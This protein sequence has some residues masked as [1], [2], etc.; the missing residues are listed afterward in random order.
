MNEYLRRIDERNYLT[1]REHRK[2]LDR[3]NNDLNQIELLK[4]ELGLE[5]L[6][7]K[8]VMKQLKKQD[9]IL[10]ILKDKTPF[11]SLIKTTQSQC[12]YESKISGFK[13]LTFHEYDL[14]KEWLEND[15]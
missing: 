15:K 13:P 9:K 4:L 10:E 2:L 14:I 11:L 6:K 5:K 1:E 12:E 3:L 7:V 8:D